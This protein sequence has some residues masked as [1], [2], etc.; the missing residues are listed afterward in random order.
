MVVIVTLHFAKITY[1]FLTLLLTETYPGLTKESYC[2]STACRTT[3]LILPLLVLALYGDSVRT[4]TQPKERKHACT[5]VC[6]RPVIQ[7]CTS[8]LHYWSTSTLSHRDLRACSVLALHDVLVSRTNAHACIH[9]TERRIESI[10]AWR[11]ACMPASASAC[12]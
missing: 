2:A 11:R 4:T 12:C 5:Y 1:L 8:R 10:E 3:F 9:R 6:P 7:A